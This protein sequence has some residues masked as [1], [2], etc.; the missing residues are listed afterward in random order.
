MSA[1]ISKKQMPNPLATLQVIDE[2]IVGPV[3][4][5][6]KRLVMPYVVW[7]NGTSDQKELIYTYEESVFD[8]KDSGS[9]NLAGMI[10]AQLALNYGLFCKSIT[11]DGRFD[12]ADQRFLKDMMENTSKEIFVN[13]ILSPNPFLSEAV[14][15]IP[16]EKRERY[17]L[18]TIQFIN[19][20]F[21]NPT[22]P[23]APWVIDRKKHCVLSSGGK[24]SLVSYGLLKELGKA[25]YPIFGNESGRHWFTAL[26]GYRYLKNS[27]PNTGRVWMN[28]DRIFNWML[29]HLPFVRQDFAKLRADDY[30]IRLWT[31]AVFLFG[32]LPLMK[33]HGMARLVIGD[34]YDASQRADFHGIRHYSGLYDQ[35][36]FF[37]EALTAFF[38]KKNWNIR[39]FSILRPLSELL[40]L[41]ILVKR[42]PE[43]QRHQISCHA[44]HEHDGV[45]RPCGKCEKC[46]R[47]VGMLTALDADPTHCGYTP[48]QI[49]GALKSLATHKVKQIG[50][51]AAHLFYIL[52]QKGVFT[53]TAKPHPEI[54]NLRFD[55]ERSQIGNIPIDL[56]TGLYNIMLQYAD[57][58]V[59]RNQRQWE[60]FDLLKDEE[61][62]GTAF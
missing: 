54:M 31:V 8:P 22:P 12:I 50:S 59:R 21:T 26:N 55:R 32:V 46:R 39:Q 2:L 60:P 40:I 53:T 27:D 28:S 42:Y 25:V 36:R 43:I 13:K 20:A 7:Q 38:D 34:E 51:D 19:T 61:V 17:T 62:V 35:S 5:E 15:A 16:I 23:P 52:G 24:D 44:T 29:R 37:D 30:P 45:I 49:D 3:K 4:V 58:A 18:A 56:R 11:F 6:P 10:G 33:K 47:I 14:K 9:Q 57:G 48:E 1:E 41:K